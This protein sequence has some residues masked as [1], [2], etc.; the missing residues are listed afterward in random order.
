MHVIKKGV[1]G[2]I[3]NDRL[4]HVRVVRSRELDREG[5]EGGSSL[6][7]GRELTYKRAPI[8]YTRSTCPISPVLER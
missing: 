7:S 2:V 4:H 1:D 5:T 8:V 6:T 3:R